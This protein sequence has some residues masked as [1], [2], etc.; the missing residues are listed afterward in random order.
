IDRSANGQPCGGGNFPPSLSA[1]TTQPTA[2]S[3]S[4][5]VLR[6]SRNDGTQQ[7]ASVTAKL[8]K[9]VLAKL[10]G[11]PYCPEAALGAISGREGAAAEEVAKPSCPPASQ[12]GSVSV[13]VGAG[14]PFAV[15]PGKVYLAGPYKGAPL[16]LEAIVPALAGP[17][18]LGN[19]AVRV[20][21][22]L[23]P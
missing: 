20:A 5:F 10:A 14:T 13:A 11:V 12:V 19:V 22:Q 2:G 8:P 18:D 16:S 15:N 1:G 17:F 7:L 3:Y 9:G 21:L 4:P 23:D 6:V